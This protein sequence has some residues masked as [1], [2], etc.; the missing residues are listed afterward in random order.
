MTKQNEIAVKLKQHMKTA[1]NKVKIKNKFAE[2]LKEK[3]VKP[4]R[5]METDPTQVT[6]QDEIYNFGPVNAVDVINPVDI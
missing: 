1:D 4:K 6:E 2:K 5:K 3:M